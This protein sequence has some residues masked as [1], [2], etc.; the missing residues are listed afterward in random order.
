MREYLKQCRFFFVYA[1]VF[2]FFVNLLML[3][4]PIYMM[5][6]FDRVLSSHSNE[7]LVMLTLITVGAFAVMSMLEV[8]RSLLLTRGGVALD[9]LVAGPVLE[10]SLNAARRPGENPYPYAMRD[11]NTVRDF[12]TGRGIMAFFDAPWAPILVIVIY[13][14]HPLFG[15]IATIGIA[16]L[17]GLAVLGDK[18]TRATVEA[19]RSKNRKASAFVEASMQNAEAVYAMGMVPAVTARWR[20]LNDDALESQASASGR[21]G[22]I[23]ATSKFVRTTLSVIMLAAGAYLIIDLHVTP[24]VMIAATLILG[25][26]LAPVEQVLAGW[27]GMVEA[28]EA[29]L[30]LSKM[31]QHTQQAAE[32]MPLP[33]PQGRLVLEKV[34]FARSITSPIL[35]NVSFELEP[36]ESLAIIG[37]SA[38]GKSTL[39]RIIM[40]VWQPVTGA[41]RLDGAS[42]ADWD[43]QQ[44][45]AHLGYLPQD[46]ELFDGTVAENIARLGDPE[47]CHDQIVEAAK[48]AMVHELVLH[49]P[50]GY[51]SRIGRAGVVLSGGQRQ[52]V[53]LARALFGRPKLVVLDE[54]NSNLDSDGEVALMQ[55]I[56]NLKEEGVTVVVI[57]HRPSLLGD[58]DKML[59]LKNGAIDSFGPRQEIMAKLTRQPTP[60]R[61]QVVG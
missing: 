24:G 45:A 49:L 19:A 27:K 16:I 51:D 10:E 44:L 54:P 13:L 22:K 23:V 6:V 55:A 18:T 40:G 5:Q 35:R 56:R 53:A 43:R 61:P 2:S 4:S 30:R 14:F 41:V 36:G 42:L 12:L 60:M 17:F 8:F 1:A 20:A 7:T 46:V 50:N 38:A 37:P 59:V 57:S 39:A 48:K 9:R 26:A 15:V 58:I 21:A 25:R 34:S 52:R 3:A 31:M 11:V 32:P 29:Y 47:Q 28:R 33:E